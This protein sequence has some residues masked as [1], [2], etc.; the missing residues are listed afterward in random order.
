MDEEAPLEI[1]DREDVQVLSDVQAMRNYLAE[2]PKLAARMLTFMS[3]E[4]EEPREHLAQLF[5]LPAFA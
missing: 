1:C 2:H 4:E 5:G 3:A